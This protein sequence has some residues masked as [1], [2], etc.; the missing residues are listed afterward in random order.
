MLL[1]LDLEGA[2]LKPGWDVRWTNHAHLLV[3]LKNNKTN[4]HL[5]HY[6]LLR[7]GSLS[8][9]RVHT[10]DS[11]QY[12][13]EV[14]DERGARMKTKYFELQVEPGESPLSTVP[15]PLL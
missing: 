2:E 5:G 15:T 3:S 4:G 1:R 11:G 13:L 7:D 9:S 14:Y 12:R 10:E 6:V 8:F